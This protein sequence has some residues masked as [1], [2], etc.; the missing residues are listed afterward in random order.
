M[1][2]VETIGRIRRE[3]FFKGKTI[4]E[5]VR[6]LKVS[7]NTV[8][9]V[10]RSG[11]TAFEYERDIQPRPKL[12]GWTADLDALLAGHAAKSRPRAVDAD[13]ALRGA[14]RAWLSR[15]LRCRAALR[16]TMEQGARAIL[17]PNGKRD[18]DSDEPRWLR[19]ERLQLASKRYFV[20]A[21]NHICDP[22]SGAR[23][24]CPA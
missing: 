24:Q 11:Q 16:R 2:T 19:R 7:R 3:Y 12:G 6:D 20:V 17:R 18:G 9:K 13:P 1:L 5:I 22:F 8:R 10:L 14:A 21:Q 4:K 23:A 15:R